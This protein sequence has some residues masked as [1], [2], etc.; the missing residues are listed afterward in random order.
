MKDL[1]GREVTIEEAR[2][3]QKRKSPVK[4]GYYFTPGTGP[5]GETCRTCQHYTI[6]RYSG[7]YRKCYLNRANWTHSAGTDILASAPACKFWEVANDD[8]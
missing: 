7:T 8:E 3:L 2:K 6:R 5:A 1:F 4:R